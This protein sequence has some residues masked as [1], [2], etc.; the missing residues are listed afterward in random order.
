MIKQLYEWKLICTRL[1][2]E[3]ETGCENDIKEYLR[4]ININNWT[5]HMQD[6][7]NWKEVI[8][9]VKFSNNETSTP[10]EEQEQKMSPIAVIF[11]VDLEGDIYQSVISIPTSEI[12]SFFS[13]RI[14]A[15]PGPLLCS[16][17][18]SLMDNLLSLRFI[19]VS[20]ISHTLSVIS[21]FIIFK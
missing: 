5:K 2:E 21:F 9:K 16:A 13:C 11:H 14:F 8:E 18:P 10:E 1:A 12:P 6:Q 17:K 4:I 15:F 20:I 3:P 7:V 19:Y